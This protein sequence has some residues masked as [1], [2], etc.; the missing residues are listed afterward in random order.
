M[1]TV[2]S[3]D[4]HTKAIIYSTHAHFWQTM[5]TVDMFA[6]YKKMNALFFMTPVLLLHVHLRI[7]SLQEY[8]YGNETWSCR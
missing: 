4:V 1:L 7:L 2:Q 6:L 3:L 8:I 5:T